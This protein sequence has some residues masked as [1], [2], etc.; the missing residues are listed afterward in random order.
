MRDWFVYL[1]E[2]KSGEIKIGCSERPEARAHNIAMASPCE[3]RLIA[4]WA[5]NFSDEKAL[6]RQFSELRI[7]R[8]WF[9]PD[10]DLAGFV[11]QMRGHGLEKVAAWGGHYADEAAARR[12]QRAARQSATLKAAWA[13]PSYRAQQAE[14][15]EI[16]KRRRSEAAPAP[17]TEAA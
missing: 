8:E 16:V 13:N 11:A 7:Y 1:I 14:F 9:R 6:H 10:G 2:A 5:G 3:V 12:A 15:R 17:K 4:K